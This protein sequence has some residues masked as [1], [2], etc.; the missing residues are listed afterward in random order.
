MAAP[1]A[2]TVLPQTIACEQL[3]VPANFMEAEPNEETRKEKYQEHILSRDLTCAICAEVPHNPFT[4]HCGATLC[5]LCV[6]SAFN[7]Q[8]NKCPKCNA[9][10]VVK[11]FFSPNMQARAQ[12]TQLKATCAFGCETIIDTV[13]NIVD[14]QVN[15]CP[16]RMIHCLVC[17]KQIRANTQVEHTQTCETSCKFCKQMVRVTMRKEHL[18]QSCMSQ[19]ST[20]KEMCLTLGLDRHRS[21]ECT[22]RPVSCPQCKDMIPHRN[23]SHHIAETCIMTQVECPRDCG[24]DYMRKEMSSHEA[25]CELVM[26]T[27]DICQH[28]C[29]R[30][31]IPAH[32][33]DPV[34]HIKHLVDIHYKEMQ[35]LNR[36]NLKLTEQCTAL[37]MKVE[38][39]DKKVEE[40]SRQMLESQLARHQLPQQMAQVTHSLAVVQADTMG[41]KKTNEH[42]A[43]E[44][45]TMKSHMTSNA[46]E[47]LRSQR[48]VTELLPLMLCPTI[49]H[50]HRTLYLAEL[51]NNNCD[52][53]PVEQGRKKH[54]GKTMGRYLG[55]R[56][57]GTDDIDMC[58]TC[59]SKKCVKTKEM[60]AMMPT[61]VSDQSA[62]EPMVKRVRFVAPEQ[63]SQATASDSWCP[64]EEE[65]LASM[66]SAQV[67]AV[68]R[69]QRPI[70]GKPPRVMAPG[71]IY[72]ITPFNAKMTATKENI[73]VQS[74]HMEFEGMKVRRGPNWIFGEEHGDDL[75][76]II[77]RGEQEG[78]VMVSWYRGHQNM[79][80]CIDADDTHHLVYA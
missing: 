70:M 43:S 40:M 12:I 71:V 38:A 31:D 63:T 33:A 13:R 2:P 49:T 51:T 67:V 17:K 20:C 41:C 78:T 10:G 3:V 69:T 48:E 22:L 59:A 15:S 61:C 26:L 21:Q 42:I 27:C 30:K 58:L 80:Y 34:P 79:C 55:Y 73:V 36:V 39:S 5:P 1:S 35:L 6:T 4:G 11:G 57:P 32:K 53:C 68:A 54:I 60:L 29:V 76:F 45:T 14:H 64:R 65:T 46:S 62:A 47:I 72:R 44:M 24:K 23:M 19:C 16:L 7:A 18:E 9:L 8:P 75:G 74:H 56:A 25:Q 28:Q 52:F 77:C 50:E 37:F 66:P